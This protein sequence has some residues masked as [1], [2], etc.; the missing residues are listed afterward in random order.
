MRIAVNGMFWGMGATGSGK[1][2][3][4]LLPALTEIAPTAQVTLYVTRATA[5]SGLQGMGRWTTRPLGTPFDGLQANMAKL[6]FEQ[7]SF[8]RACY[9]ACDV[10]H[11]PYLASPYYAAVPTIVT[12]HDL[13]PLLLPDYRGSPW[14]RLYMRLVSEAARRSSL[15]ITDSHASARDIERLL[16]VPAQRIRVVHLAADAIYHPISAAEQ[17]AVLAR[18]HIPRPYLLYLGGF[19]PRKNVAGLLRAFAAAQRGLAGVSLV[20]AGKLPDGSSA[21][22]R[23][24]RPLVGELGLSDRVHLTGWVEE[25]DSPALYAGAIGFVFPS[26]YEGFGLP[27]LEALSCGTP[28]IVGAGSSLEEVGGPGCVSV[29][30]EDTAA[31]SEAMV[32]LCEDAAWRHEL[33]EAGLRHARR[34]SWMET[35]RRTWDAYQEAIGGA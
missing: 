22:A 3:H 24:P 15:I 4:Q 29:Q 10:A 32:R 17:E 13:I 35:A 11:V 1:Y 31:L 18:L 9:G 6:W 12:I 19:D 34:F 2:I 14:V 30:A 25:E 23:D 26:F 5:A 21:L 28:A 27:V 33:A 16:R 8:S 7:V 20:V